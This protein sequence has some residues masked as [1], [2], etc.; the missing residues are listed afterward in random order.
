MQQ[1]EQKRRQ[2]LATLIDE[3]IGALQ[4]QKRWQSQ[5][6]SEQALASIEPFAIDSLNF[7]Q[8][9]QFIFIEKITALLQLNL[10]LPSAMA[11]TP[12]A[13]EYFKEQ[14]GDSA[15]ILAIITRIDLI[16][17]EKNSC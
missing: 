5:R 1:F 11:I 9:L 8:W 2:L 3:L 15:A 10:A 4:A 13:V 7:T 14:G 16:I 17:N 12:M 6:P